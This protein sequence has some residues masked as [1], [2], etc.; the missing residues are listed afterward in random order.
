ME[1]SIYRHNVLDTHFEHVEQEL[2]GKLEVEDLAL[3]IGGPDLSQPQ[4]QPDAD[5]DSDDEGDD[6]DGIMDDLLPS[7]S[8]VFLFLA[9]R[10]HDAHLFHGGWC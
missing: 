8:T 4:P 3:V 1:R 7:L 10:V 6:E 2:A 5:D 9:H